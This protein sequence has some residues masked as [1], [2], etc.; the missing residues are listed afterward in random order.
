MIATLKAYKALCQAMSQLHILEVLQAYQEDFMRD[1]AGHKG[2]KWITLSL[3]LVLRETKR[4]A[5]SVGFN[6]V[7]IVA[8]ERHLW[9]N[10]TDIHDSNSAFNLNAPMSQT[11]LFGGKSYP[12]VVPSKLQGS[13]KQSATLQ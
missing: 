7:A 4:T 1:L 10:L 5:Q 11:G 9:L 2:C 12:M 3:D 13:K 6:M 8:A